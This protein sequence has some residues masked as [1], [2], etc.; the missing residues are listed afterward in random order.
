MNNDKA[1]RI[2]DKALRQ[3]RKTLSEY[4]AKQVLAAYDIPITKEILIKDKT[5]LEKGMKKIGFPLVMK[6]CS[7]DIAHKTEKGLIHVDIRTATEAKKAFR[8]I[9][10]GME[11][12][13]GGVLMQEMIKGRRELVMGLTRDPQFGPCVMFGLGGIFTEILRD[14]SFR[15][16]PLEVRDAHEMMQE[17]RGHKILDAVRG[18]EAADKKRLTDMLIN[19]GRIGLEIPEVSEIDLNPVIISGSNPVVVDALVILKQP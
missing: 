4:E 18:M 15:R 1:I 13:E 12:F 8:E 5:N 19:I 16:A 7:A 6:G 11:G 17:I 3:G 9:M 10:A 14:I 2:I